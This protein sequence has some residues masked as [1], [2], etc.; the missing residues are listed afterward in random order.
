MFLVLGAL[1]RENVS[2]YHPPMKLREGN[3]FS[4]ACVCV[5]RVPRGPLPIMH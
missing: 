1:F 2:H 3:V 5:G 4:C